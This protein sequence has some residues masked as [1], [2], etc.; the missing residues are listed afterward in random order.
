MADDEEEADEPAVELGE[1]PAVE[2]A[3]VARVASRLTWP[4]DASEV[5]RKEGE[6]V[7]RTPDGP[8]ALAD[9]LAESDVSYFDSRQSFVAAVEDV[10][11][12]GPVATDG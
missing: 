11:G 8:R 4:A 5:E 12:P 2:G 9:V 3:P 1:G 10:T 7:L 6:S